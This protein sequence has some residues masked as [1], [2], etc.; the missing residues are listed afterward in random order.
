MCSSFI[1]FVNVATHIFWE[2]ASPD[3]RYGI[4][5]KKNLY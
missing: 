3:N 4:F 1:Q 5:S 2:C